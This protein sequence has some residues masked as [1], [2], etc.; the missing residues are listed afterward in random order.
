MKLLGLTGQK[1]SG[2][3]TVA[4]IL[5]EQLSPKKV[6]QLGF[7]D[8]LKQEI[9][10]AVGRD[11]HY[12][13][14]HKANFRLI[15]QGWGTDFRRQLCGQ[16]YWL[17]KMFHKIAALPDDTHLCIITDVRFLNE[18]DLVQQ[19][20]GKIWRIVRTLD[21]K[22]NHPSEQELLQIKEDHTIR[23]THSLA[24]LQHEVMLAYQRTMNKQ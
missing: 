23:N 18:A 15:L 1:Q 6:V 24:E 10:A 21:N 8:A 4:D 7:A 19:V 16:D 22:D 11:V 20:G 9:S 17:K 14:E 13:E 2:K 3:N 12:I 5:K